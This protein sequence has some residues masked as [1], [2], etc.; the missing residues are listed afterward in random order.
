MKIKKEKYW[1]CLGFQ[2]MTGDR[3]EYPKNKLVLFLPWAHYWIYFDKEYIKPF[4]YN[5]YNSYSQQTYPQY[6]ERVFGITV[7]DG[8]YLQIKYGKQEDFSNGLN[9]SDIKEDRWSCFLPWKEK[10]H[11]YHHLLMLDRKL[12][13]D[14]TRAY[15]SWEIKKTQPNKKF[16]FYDYDGEKITATCSI[17][18]RKWEHGT[19]FFKWLKYFVKPIISTS[20]NIE[21]SSEVG[22]RKGSWKGGTL[23]HSIDMLDDETV[24]DCFKRYC[25][26]YSLIFIGVS[27][28]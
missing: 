9:M 15:A 25:E 19:G 5:Y 13:C 26:K 11:I 24:Q 10:K 8:N 17:E 22:H 7:S 6:A 3:E 27:N 14:V 4:K 1:D 2:F 23:G 12:W 21:F 28:A 18:Q 16:D 20:L